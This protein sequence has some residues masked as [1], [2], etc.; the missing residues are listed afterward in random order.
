V[1][2]TDLSLHERAVGGDLDKVKTLERLLEPTD[3]VF[4]AQKKIRMSLSIYKDE[5]KKKEMET[6]KI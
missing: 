2:G 5:S 4:L 3:E 1:Q 6:E